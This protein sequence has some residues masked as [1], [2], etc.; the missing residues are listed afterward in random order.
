MTNNQCRK[1]KKYLHR[2]TQQ[3]FVVFMKHYKDGK[4]MIEMCNNKSIC[5]CVTEKQL[6]DPKLW[7][8]IL[9]PDKKDTH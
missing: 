9:E 6:D 5:Y 4:W 2:Q 1:G 3:E 7:L 8:E